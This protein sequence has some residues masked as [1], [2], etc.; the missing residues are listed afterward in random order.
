MSGFTTKPVVGISDQVRHKPG[1]TTTEDGERLEISDL[2]EGLHY[3]CNEN[4]VADQLRGRS[5]PLLAHMTKAGFLMT[6]LI[7]AF[8]QVHWYKAFCRTEQMSN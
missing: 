5:E 2:V 7:L 8:R 1:C 6:R 3:H 4:N